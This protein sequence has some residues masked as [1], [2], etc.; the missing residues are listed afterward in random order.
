MLVPVDLPHDAS[1]Q[2]LACL[3]LQLW[4]LAKPR[5]VA[6]D[7]VVPDTHTRMHTHSKAALL[8]LPLVEDLQG[9]SHIYVVFLCVS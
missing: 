8:T 3:P 4:P 2:D 6:G 5:H 7:A 1:P 9:L